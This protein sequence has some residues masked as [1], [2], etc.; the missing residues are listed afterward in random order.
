MTAVRRRFMRRG[1]KRYP[2]LGGRRALRST[3]AAHRP[4]TAAHAG[5]IGALHGRVAD[6]FDVVPVRIEDERAVVVWVV[7]RA[8]ARG[9][10]VLRTC[11]DPGGIEG[12]HRRTVFGG[13]RNVRGRRARPVGGGPEVRSLPPNPEERST[14]KAEPSV[15]AKLGDNPD[16]ERRE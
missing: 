14:L 10:V 11:R 1:S 15:E 12:V 7:K 9:S 13:E 2:M 16:F 6:G 3:P 5:T 8:R 4:A